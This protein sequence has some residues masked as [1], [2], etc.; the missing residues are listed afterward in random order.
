MFLVATRRKEER[1]GKKNGVY[2]LNLFCGIF[3]SIF[4]F[5]SR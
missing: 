3:F 2:F 4:V 1:K 5:I